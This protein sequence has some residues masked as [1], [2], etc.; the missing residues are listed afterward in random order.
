MF[1]VRLIFLNIFFI[2]KVNMFCSNCG[3]KT[4]ET[5]NFC[6]GCG[7]SISANTDNKAIDSQ[8]DS[9]SNLENNSKYSYFSKNSGE[10]SNCGYEGKFGFVSKRKT[11]L[12]YLFVFIQ[13]CILNF[14]WMFN[15]NLL[16]GAVVGFVV[17]YLVK[18]NNF[19]NKYTWACPSCE[20]EF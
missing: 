19:Y 20:K 4:D 18:D 14:A 2:K 17:L 13:L 9:I 15:W 11:F 16:M 12:F 5:A 8:T 10:C 3:I 1:H 6:G 7:S